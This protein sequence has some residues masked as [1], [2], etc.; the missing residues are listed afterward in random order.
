M[1]RMEIRRR[2]PLLGDRVAR[3]RVDSSALADN[4]WCDPS[5]REL[6]VY[7]PPDY[8][9]TDCHYPV[10]WYLAAYTNSGR[11]AANWRGFGEN[12]FERIDR[13][14][15]EQAMA[16]VI[17]VAPDCFNSLGGNQYLNSP[18][19]GAYADYLHDEL[20]PLID[21]RFRTLKAREHRGLFGKSSGGYGA[22]RL[23]M[24]RP[25][26]WGALADHSGDVDFE[27]VY[28]RDFPKVAEV[29]R[30][31]DGDPGAFL[32]HFWAAN[33]RRGDDFTTLMFLCMAASYAPEPELE[34]G[35]ALP[36]DLETLEIDRSR[37]QRWLAH[38][39]LNLVADHAAALKSMRA[40]FIDCGNRDEYHLQFGA[41]RLHRRL[42]ELGIDHR[43]EEFDGTHSNIDHR[44][45]VSL[46]YLSQ[47][48]SND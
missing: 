42:N 40:I 2:S 21:R 18:A 7:L 47:A 4:P 44:L 30:A 29:L 14:I 28:R 16:P 10:L 23:A 22:L 45:D 1:T 15:A 27:W 33:E 34:L 6:L 26:C 38:D 12:H 31:H 5:E 46:P 41:R 32:R 8:D 24:E 36:F 13:L 3:L 17:A 48:L 11:G 37:W 35:F 39:P 25:D 19:V 9:Q 43:Y 20:V